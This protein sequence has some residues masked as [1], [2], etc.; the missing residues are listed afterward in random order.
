M[1]YDGEVL[2][3]VNTDAGLVPDPATIIDHFYTEFDQLLQLAKDVE[4]TS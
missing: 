3:G 4:E 1:S 2:V